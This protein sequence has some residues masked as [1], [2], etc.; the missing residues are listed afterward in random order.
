[1]SNT[2]GQ[3]CIP[4]VVEV[5]DEV[6]H[7]AGRRHADQ[8]VLHQQREHLVR[9]HVLE[10]ADFI[11]GQPFVTCVRVQEFCFVSSEARQI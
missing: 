11:S 8:P 6:G 7:P 10:L 1:M 5:T 2:T 4:E 9:V 3:E